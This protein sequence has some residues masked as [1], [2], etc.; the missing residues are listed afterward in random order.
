MGKATKV[1]AVV[2]PGFDID[3]VRSL[4]HQA[5]QGRDLVVVEQHELTADLL[6]IGTWAALL[7]CGSKDSET[8][9]LIDR[10]RPDLVVVTLEM[11]EIDGWGTIPNDET[12]SLKW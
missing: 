5:H 7:H 8:I 9:C 1:L 12:C 2:D 11:A 3:T 6:Q 4:L 10:L